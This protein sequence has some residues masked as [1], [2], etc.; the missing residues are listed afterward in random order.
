MRTRFEKIKEHSHAHVYIT[1]KRHKIAQSDAH[2]NSTGTRRVRLASPTRFRWLYWRDVWCAFRKAFYRSNSSAFYGEKMQWKS[3]I[4]ETFVRV[5]GGV[6]REKSGNFQLYQRKK[7]KR[8]AED[9]NV[10]STRSSCGFSSRAA[11]HF[12]RKK[13]RVGVRAVVAPSYW[14]RC[15]IFLIKR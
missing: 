14:N 3:R 6:A 7:R 15:R 5:G 2:L 10:P 12:R 11:T 8:Q 9:N 1:P 13:R 4:V